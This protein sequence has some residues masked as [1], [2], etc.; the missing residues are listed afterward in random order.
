MNIIIRNEEEKDYRRVEEVA[1]E[2]FW[3]LYFPGA[4]E[5]CVVHKMRTSPDLIRELCFVIEVDGVVEGAIF[6]THSQ[7]ERAEKEPIKTISF[8][9]MFIS[10]KFHRQSLG[11]Q[12]I[13]YSIEKA[14]S[15]GFRG[16]LTLGY[17][18]HYEPYGF[19][20]GKKY[21]I[22]MADGKY[23]KGLLAL[24]LYEGAF[25][26][27]AGIACFSTDLDVSEEE[28]AEFEK[29]FPD[30]EKK[31]LPCQAEFELACAQLDD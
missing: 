15:M 28:V 23:Y 14:K 3:N 21:G 19:V 18:H 29:A 30:K 24:P 16:I 31:A 12:L 5:H 10:P 20:G 26:N 6:Y 7:I 8:G 4:H 22:S 13:T 2:A 1:R 27:I 9:P 11:R 17:P 25:D